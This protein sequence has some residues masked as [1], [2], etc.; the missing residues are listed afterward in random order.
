MLSMWKRNYLSF[1][2][3]ITLIKTMWS[4]LPIYCVFALDAKY[5]KGDDGPI[6]RDF[7]QEGRSD[8]R[9]IAPYEMK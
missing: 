7:L 9:I 4:N 2:R 1:G 3:R 5:G 8:K 6:R